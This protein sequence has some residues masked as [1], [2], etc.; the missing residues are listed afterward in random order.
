MAIVNRDLGV[1]E[2]RQELSYSNS[3]EI[4]T[5]ASVI[6]LNVPYACDL[7]ALEVAVLGASGAPTL[8]F[9][10]KRWTSA[11]STIF[12]LGISAMTV[13]AV[14][15]LSGPAQGWSGIRALGNTLL[16]L[17][18]G[19]AI[20]MTTGVANTSVEQ[21]SVALVVKR[22]ADIVSALGLAT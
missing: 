14:F 8:D 5:G 16:Q 21:L 6:M 3:E 13:S 17:Q 4:V 20:C 11:G 10:V 2:Q 9:K 18:R 7:Q 15:G 1:S 12:S 19:D 22:T